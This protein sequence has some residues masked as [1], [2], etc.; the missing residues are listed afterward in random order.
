MKFSTQLV[1]SILG[2][3]VLSLS[4]FG[5]IAYWIIDDGHE[6]THNQLLQQMVKTIH[7][8][9][10][11]TDT[12]TL[13]QASLDEMHEIFAT[14]DT[15]LLIENI[16]GTR[17]IANNITQSPSALSAEI[18]L[19][20]KTSTP[21]ANYGSIEVDNHAYHWNTSQL[22]NSQYRLTLLHD[23]S[24]GQHQSDFKLGMRLLTTSFIIIWRPSG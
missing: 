4:V 18:K 12:K 11:K 6:Q 21:T 9:W 3:T 14:P 5:G 2:I 24:T 22:P 16:D 19:V 1:L 8:H 7:R 10:L 15:T 17:L 23:D 20:I 13:T